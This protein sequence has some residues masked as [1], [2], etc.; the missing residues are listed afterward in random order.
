MSDF[1][2]VMDNTMDSKSNNV[3]YCILLYASKKLEF[4]LYQ[5]KTRM[6]TTG[7]ISYDI[8]ATDSTVQT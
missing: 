7:A 3:Q 8:I 4:L 2:R 5:A 1:N 6:G